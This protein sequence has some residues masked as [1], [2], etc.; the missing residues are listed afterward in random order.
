MQ[1]SFLLHMLAV[2][3]DR[4]MVGVVTPHGVLFRG[5]VRARE[6]MSVE[7]TPGQLGEAEQ[8]R[9]EAVANTDRL[10]SELGYAPEG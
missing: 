5:G 6:L 9:H 3:N 1:N 7:E 2:T 8:T 4:G 10:L